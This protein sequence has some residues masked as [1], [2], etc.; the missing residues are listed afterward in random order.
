M[1]LAQREAAADV[2]NSAILAATAAKMAD[3]KQPAEGPSKAPTQL[4]AEPKPQ[5]FSALT[6]SLQRTGPE[7]TVLPWLCLYS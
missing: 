3:A 2:V 1:H 4:S 7:C 5:V 6:A